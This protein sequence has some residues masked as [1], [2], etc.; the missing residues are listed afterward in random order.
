MNLIFQENLQSDLDTILSCFKENQ[1]MVTSG[2][3]QFMSL[4]KH[5]IHE[6]VLDIFLNP[7]K[8]VK[9]PELT[10]DKYLKFEY[11]NISQIFEK[12]LTQKLNANKK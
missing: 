7:E 6:I 11:L 10:I 3:L 4:G 5:T 8:I 1:M 2:K 9:L 12:L